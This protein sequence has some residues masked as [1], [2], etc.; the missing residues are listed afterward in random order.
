MGGFPVGAPGNPTALVGGGLAFGVRYLSVTL[1]RTGMFL[2]SSQERASRAHRA[3][4][5]RRVDLAVG[6]GLAG[7]QSQTDT[8]VPAVLWWLHFDGEDER[9]ERTLDAAAHDRSLWLAL[10]IVGLAWFRR[11]LDIGPTGVRLLLARCRT[12]HRDNRPGRLAPSTA[13]RAR[14]A[15]DRRCPGRVY[16]APQGR[17]RLRRQAW[18]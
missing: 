1:V 14:G 17:A 13:G 16:A 4:R 11:L 3:D 10:Y 18:A 2:L 5:A 7:R 6:I 15:P 12:V 8:V 9:T